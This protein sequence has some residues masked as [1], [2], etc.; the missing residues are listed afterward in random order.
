M[1]KYYKYLKLNNIFYKVDGKKVYVYSDFNRF[2][3]TREKWRLLKKN[4]PGFY[5][6]NFD[7]DVYQELTEAE[8]MIEMLWKRKNIYLNEKSSYHYI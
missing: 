6:S 8:M 3:D 2:S 1:I 7:K 4:G 5:P